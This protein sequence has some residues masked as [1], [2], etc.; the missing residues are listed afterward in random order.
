MFKYLLNKKPNIEV[1]TTIEDLT[2]IEGLTII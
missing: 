2:T 1:L